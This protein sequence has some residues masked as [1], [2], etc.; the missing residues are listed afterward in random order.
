LL[1]QSQLSQRR[2]HS[3]SSKETE[4]VFKRIILL[5][6]FLHSLSIIVVVVTAAD[7]DTRVAPPQNNALL[8]LWRQRNSH[9]PS[10][11]QD[12]NFSQLNKLNFF[13]KATARTIH[14]TSESVKFRKETEKKPQ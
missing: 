4:K 8:F 11:H 2:Q 13:F 1:A 5:C 7:D 14:D 6:W 10:S 12:I 3:S 9:E